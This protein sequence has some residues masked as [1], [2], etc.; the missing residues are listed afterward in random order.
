MISL[1][2]KTESAP[3]ATAKMI[4]N[5]M[6]SQPPTLGQP[7]DVATAPK[8][9]PRD[10]NGQYSPGPTH[11]GRRSRLFHWTGVPDSRREARTRARSMA[12]DKQAVAVAN[13]RNE[14]A[15]WR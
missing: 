6:E 11:A 13:R 12:T 15:W 4:A 2:P 9:A 10:R 5:K 1:A 8:A 14:T 7:H 3:S